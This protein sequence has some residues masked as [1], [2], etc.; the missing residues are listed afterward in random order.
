VV[1][2]VPSGLLDT[3]AETLRD[4]DDASVLAGALGQ[5]DEVDVGWPIGVSWA[6]SYADYLA[7]RPQWD[8]WPTTSPSTG[9][10][11]RRNRRRNLG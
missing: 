11:Q 3:P 4:I 5:T 9:S 8:T 2:E 1:H 6:R 10:R 7:N